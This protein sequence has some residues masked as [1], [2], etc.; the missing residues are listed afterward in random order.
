MVGIHWI[1]VPTNNLPSRFLSIIIMLTNNN[2]LELTFIGYRHIIYTHQ[3]T[4]KP[5]WGVFFFA[6]NFN[7]RDVIMY[8]DTLSLYI[9]TKT[10]EN[11]LLYSYL[12]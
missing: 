7:G 1:W 6:F 2:S 11:R 9:E 3:V 4:W 10:L 8:N 5:F 12:W